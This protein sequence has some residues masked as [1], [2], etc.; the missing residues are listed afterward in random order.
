MA[1]EQRA[2]TEVYVCRAKQACFQVGIPKANVDL[3]YRLAWSSNA[4]AI[5]GKGEAL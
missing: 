4:P 1:L 2:Y 3:G 5:S